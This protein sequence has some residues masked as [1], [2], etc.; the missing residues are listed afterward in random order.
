MDHFFDWWVCLASLLSLI[1]LSSCFSMWGKEMIIPI[2][3]AIRDQFALPCAISVQQNVEELSFQNI[4]LSTQGSERQR[5][6]AACLVSMTGSICLFIL[7]I[8]FTVNISLQTYKTNSLK[9]IDSRYYKLHSAL[10]SWSLSVACKRETRTKRTKNSYRRLY[11]AT[12]P[13]RLT[14]LWNI[15]N[16]HLTWNPQLLALLWACH[17]Q[18]GKRS[19]PIWISISGSS[20][21][22]WL[23]H[24]LLYH[25][26][27][28]QASTKG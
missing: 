28:C 27:P 22:S 12:T 16:C 4:Q 23:C 11:P 14:V 20:Q 26:S 24:V 21:D 5:K 1:Y 19:D 9:E 13:T 8:K 7:P 17:P 3:P 2:W 6:N 15:G 18:Q 25:S 10:R